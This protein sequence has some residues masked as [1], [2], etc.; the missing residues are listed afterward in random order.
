MSLRSMP[1]PLALAEYDHDEHGSECKLLIANEVRQACTQARTPSL[2]SSGSG[3]EDYNYSTI[4]IMQ[5]EYI[6]RWWVNQ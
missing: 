4:G 1:L 5:S 3:G 6:C 2:F